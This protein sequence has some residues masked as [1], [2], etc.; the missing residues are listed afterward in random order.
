MMSRHFSFRLDTENRFVCNRDRRQ[1]SQTPRFLLS[2]SVLTF[3]ISCSRG[4]FRN[5]L[6]H[7]IPCTAS[8]EEFEEVIQRGRVSVITERNN[9][10]QIPDRSRQATTPQACA[11]GLAFSA[12]GDAPLVSPR[13]RAEFRGAD[14]ANREHGDPSGAAERKRIDGDPREASR[15]WTY[16]QESTPGAPEFGGQESA[17]LSF[18]YRHFFNHNTWTSFRRRLTP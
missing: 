4:T 17:T 16:R 18:Y 11:E 1:D 3:F 14:E 8:N 13:S 6:S 9:S 12:H 2:G 15:R 10:D 7:T 5:L